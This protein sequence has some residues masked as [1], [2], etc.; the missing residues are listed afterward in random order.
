L[1]FFP[2]NRIELVKACLHDY[3]YH[4]MAVVRRQGS[5]NWQVLIFLLL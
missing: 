3:L 4:I 1:F 5:G 2:K